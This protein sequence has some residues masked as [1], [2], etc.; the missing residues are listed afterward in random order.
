M[1]ALSVQDM[2]QLIRDIGDDADANVHSNAELLRY[3]NAAVSKY[4]ALLAIHAKQNLMH[5]RDVTHDGDELEAVMPYLPRIV[6]VERTSNSPRTETPPLNSGFRDRFPYLT[7][8]AGDSEGGYY[9]QN[10]QL[11]VVP[12]Q[13][14]GTNRVWVILRSPE[15]HY[16]TADATSTTSSFVMA[17][18]PTLGNVHQ[19]NDAYN[20][21]PV[22]L[23]V[24]R[25][26][27]VISDFTGSSRTAT[28]QFTFEND[29]ASAVYSI[30]PILHPEYH[31]LL[32]WDALIKARIRTDESNVDPASERKILEG[33]LIGSVTKYQTQQPRYMRR[34]SW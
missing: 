32:V 15:L 1:P 10:N 28:L 21:V 13:A 22:M 7:V 5:Y 26:V 12:A 23:T 33:L 30:L 24:T 3:L 11:G 20:M 9:I 8:S 18:T 25:E 19:V 17:S 27:N 16:G 29:P 6:S 2:I 14:S 4:D 31:M 34:T